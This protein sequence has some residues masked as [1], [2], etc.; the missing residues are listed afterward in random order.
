[1]V[2][3]MSWENHDGKKW[4]F[5]NENGTF[6]EVKRLEN[7]KISKKNQGNFRGKLENDCDLPKMALEVRLELERERFELGLL[8][9]R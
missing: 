6:F 2:S 7:M 9:R 8:V 5:S 4:Q 3:N 1:M